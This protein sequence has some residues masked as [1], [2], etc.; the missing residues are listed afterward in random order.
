MNDTDLDD[1]PDNLPMSVSP[2]FS[3][4]IAN[5]LNAVGNFSNPQYQFIP[6]RRKRITNNNNNH[7]S[8]ARK[9]SVEV[10][11]VQEEEDYSIDSGS[12]SPLGQSIGTPFTIEEQNE[13]PQHISHMNES[14]IFNASAS[15]INNSILSSKRMKTKDPLNNSEPTEDEHNTSY[16]HPD[17]SSYHNQ[18]GEHSKYSNNQTNNDKKIKYPSVFRFMKT[19]TVGGDNSGSD[20]SPEEDPIVQTNNTN[21]STHAANTP[22]GEQGSLHSFRKE[23]LA[24][25]RA[26]HDHGS[27]APLNHNTYQEDPSLNKIK[28]EIHQRRKKNLMGDPERNSPIPQQ[29]QQ[30]ILQ[31]N[32]VRRNKLER[33]FTNQPVGC[34]N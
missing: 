16:S 22:L 17:Q 8:L 20:S 23:V 34:K 15:F 7:H 24:K 6:K 19:T 27:M 5:Q 18:Y 9:P 25:K 3:T 28:D 1:L 26:S 4:K 32:E 2:R 33:Q 12:S 30:D 11:E 10:L 29:P 14:P 21:T 13:P 31:G